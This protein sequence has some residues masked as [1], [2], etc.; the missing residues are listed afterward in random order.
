M[1]AE[2]SRTFR[3][4]PYLQTERGDRVVFFAKTSQARV[5]RGGCRSLD[6]PQRHRDVIGFTFAAAED[7][8]AVVMDREW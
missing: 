2:I 5:F 6:I 1:G 4:V 7:V 8:A 3:G